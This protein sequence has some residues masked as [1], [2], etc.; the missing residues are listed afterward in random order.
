M[1]GQGTSYKS[2]VAAKKANDQ[3]SKTFGFANRVNKANLP[4]AMSDI[5]DI[6]KM[7]GPYN[8]NDPKYY[9]PALK[10]TF[11]P[12]NPLTKQQLNK[13]WSDYRESKAAKDFKVDRSVEQIVRGKDTRSPGERSADVAARRERDNQ[14]NKSLASREMDARKQSMQPMSSDPFR[15]RQMRSR[16]AGDVRLP[17]VR[18]PSR[19]G[20][21]SFGSFAKGGVV[22]K[23][24]R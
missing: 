9:D 4:S 12:N 11:N 6:R 14:F 7:T 3:F 19:S 20:F 10:R 15:N 24:K 23:K 2:P 18:L 17:D 22:R 21:M 8:A 1:S 5:K 16:L 13:K